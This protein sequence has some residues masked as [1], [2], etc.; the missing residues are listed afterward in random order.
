MY[1]IFVHRALT[2]VAPLLETARANKTVTRVRQLTIS[3]I[4]SPFN[5]LAKKEKITE[6]WEKQEEEAKTG[7]FISLLKGFDNV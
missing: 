2:H 5:K 3:R 7:R 6:A 1:R 4:P